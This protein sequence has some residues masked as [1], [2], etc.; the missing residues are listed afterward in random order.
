MWNTCL[1]I[2]NGYKIYMLVL[3]NEMVT[4]IYILGKGTKSY[5]NCLFWYKIKTINDLKLYLEITSLLS[6]LVEEK[7]C[8]TSVIYQ[9]TFVQ[10]LKKWF[11]IFYL[12]FR[13][14]T[15]FCSIAQW[16]I[17]LFD[18]NSSCF[19]LIFFLLNMLLDVYDQDFKKK[20]VSSIW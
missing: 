13:L 8:Y 11:R 4:K 12:V 14:S 1:Q 5:K 18:K 9:L 7:L 19:S 20:V 16:L 3:K 2:R 10:R 17:F 15:C 6:V